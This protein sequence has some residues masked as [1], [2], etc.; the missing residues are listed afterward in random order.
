MSPSPG[1]PSTSI[2]QENIDTVQRL[3]MGN[4]RISLHEL[5]EATRLSYGSIHSILHENLYLS[6]VCARWVPRM[7][8]DDSGAMLTRYNVTQTIFILGL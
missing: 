5:E 6:K 7:I 4:R 2:N 3:V 8:S 1:R